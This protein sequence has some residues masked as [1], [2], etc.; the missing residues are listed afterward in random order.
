VPDRQFFQ[1]ASEHYEAGRLIEA[2]AACAEGLRRS[3]RDAGLHTLFGDV[4]HAQGRLDDA[5][6][7]YDR[8]LLIDEE[9]HG[10]WYAS[11][12]A[13]LTKRVYATALA[14]FEQAAAIAPADAAAHHNLGTALFKLGLTDEAIRQFR[15]S[16]TLRDS[17]LPRTAIATS[18]PGSPGADHATVL[19]ARRDWFETHLPP[20]PART[21]SR[22]GAGGR[23]RIGYLSSFF[24]SSHWMKPV[25]GLINQHD[26]QAFDIHLFSDCPE[27]KCIGYARHSRDRFH[28]ISNLSNRDA[29][30]RIEASEIDILIDLNGY[31]Q[32]TRLAVV[33]QKP[34]TIQVAWFNS[35]ATSGM[36]CF[37]YL[38]GDEH[39]IAP[40]EEQFYTER[41]VRVPGC[42][43]TFDVRYPVPDVVDPPALNAGYVTFG[44]LASQYK[45]T[46]PVVE[47]WS[48]ILRRS[49]SSK[50]FLKN[51]TLEHEANR[52]H[53][54]CRFRQHGIAADRLEFAGPAEH[55]DFLAA[56]SRIDIAVDTFPYN[57]GTTTS[58]AIWQGVPVLTFRGDRWAGRQSTSIMRTAGLDA[59]VA[60]DVDDYVERAVRLAEDAQSPT[61]LA[62]LR[63]GMRARLAAAPLCDTIAFARAIEDLYRQFARAGAGS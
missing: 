20:A 7:A 9:L 50:L 24:E 43:L 49:P 31:S 37:D 38:I 39:V 48:R 5:I 19:A 62:E 3:P 28:D 30:A 46:P 11:G 8:A 15:R 42:Y 22:L 18:I 52:S 57:G 51:A 35:Y 47:A 41:I 2:S 23:L 14:R 26:R 61:R 16:L 55:F 54:A 10:A 33:A 40:E 6:A 17:F 34:A 44:C 32:V 53:L 13:F 4:L 27:A 59:F 1:N 56:Y 36:G 58:E 60:D 29:A 45:I 21:V 25:W 63:R 12:C